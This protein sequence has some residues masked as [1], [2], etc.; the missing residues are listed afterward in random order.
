[1]LTNILLFLGCSV[2]ALF[3]IFLGIYVT[4]YVVVFVKLLW[5]YRT[6][7]VELDKKIKEL[8]TYEK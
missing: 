6:Y 1:M 7:K 4:S 2:L 3:I 5:L 8:D